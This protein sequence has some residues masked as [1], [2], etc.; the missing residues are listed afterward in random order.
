MADH[1]TEIAALRAILNSAASRVAVD[2]MSVQHDL[3]FAAKRLAEL[4]Q[5]DDAAM[6]GKTPRPSMAVYRM[7]SDP[8]L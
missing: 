7:N 8:N 2:G 3:Q 5:E 4:L 6:L 1:S